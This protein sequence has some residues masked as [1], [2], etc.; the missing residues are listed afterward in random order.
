NDTCPRV[1]QHDAP[2]S[3]GGIVDLCC[4]NCRASRIA[5]RRPLAQSP[6][7]EVRDDR[8]GAARC[9][10]N[11]TAIRAGLGTESGGHMCSRIV[12]MFGIILVCGVV[13]VGQGGGQGRGGGSD[14]TVVLE[15]APT[16]HSTAIPK[17][18]L[19]QYL[20]EMDAKKLA[21]LRMIEGGKFN[22]NV[23]RISGAE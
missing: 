1:F 6:K 8:S 21:T 20:K 10:Y 3:S 5:H 12:T 18:K 22:V 11:P 13:G 15:K 17:E 2:T 4:L 19:D 14:Q 9:E 16:D 23:R 7:P